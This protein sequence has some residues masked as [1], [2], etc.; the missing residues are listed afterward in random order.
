[1]N[2][3][4]NAGI[5]MEI[6]VDDLDVDS[7]RPS[8]TFSGIT[9]SDGQTIRVEPA[10]IVVFV[11]PNNA[12]KSAALRELHHWIAR[13]IPQKVI[14]GA[15]LDKIG[16]ERSLRAYLERHAQKRGD[17]G[18]LH[19]TGLGY[20]IHYSHLSFFD[21][22]DD[23]HPVAPFFTSLIDTETR[24]TGS[25]P[26]PPIALYDEPPTHPIHL[27]MQDDKLAELI[28]MLFRRAFGKDLVVFSRRRLEVSSVR[29]QQT[30]QIVGEG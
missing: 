18:K 29:R 16:D 17:V 12:G 14:V 23:R 28:S 7:V 19:Y 27:L 24:L 9:F 26:A 11:G 1:M 20:D 3:S 6:S 8:L 15:S 25:N 21:R 30:R 13:S 5:R 10:E 4:F 2:Q 22:P